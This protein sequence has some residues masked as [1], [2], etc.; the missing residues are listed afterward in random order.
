[1]PM[2]RISA[3]PSSQKATVKSTFETESAFKGKRAGVKNLMKTIGISMFI[4][5]TIAVSAA[6]QNHLFVAKSS[7][8]KEDLQPTA[9]LSFVLLTIC[10]GI[11]DVLV[12]VSMPSSSS[13]SASRRAMYLVPI[14]A[15]LLATISIDDTKPVDAT[16][17]TFTYSADTG[18]CKHLDTS[19]MNNFWKK[20]CGFENQPTSHIF[21]NSEIRNKYSFDP[22]TGATSYE[23]ARSVAKLDGA[24]NAM[25]LT[26]IDAD[27]AMSL[28][29]YGLCVAFYT[30]CSV[31]CIPV[32][33]CS[34]FAESALLRV[35]NVLARKW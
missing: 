27:T 9:L 8:D 6:L 19:T 35:K 16:C 31:S 11:C 7:C 5:V 22:E 21:I 32:R 29:D 13:L 15:F 17:A 4:V 10:S 1:M 30:P 20:R 25:I 23:L 12:Q 26:P 24:A 18:S 28:T 3:T 14:V 2:Q 33:L 34:S